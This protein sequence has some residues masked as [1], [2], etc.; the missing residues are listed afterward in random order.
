MSDDIVTP[1]RRLGPGH[2]HVAPGMAVPA[3]ARLQIRRTD[4]GSRA[5]LGRSG[6]QEAPFAHPA[7][8][9][10]DGRLLLGPAIC[11]HI[12]GNIEVEL[13]IEGADGAPLW[14]SGR[15]F[16]PEV[17]RAGRVRD[18][19]D[20]V[21][22]GLGK[23]RTEDRIIR[24]PVK[25]EN[26]G[27]GSEGG[28]GGT[29][30][31]EGQE[32][33]GGDPRGPDEPDEPPVGPGP[34]GDQ[35]EEKPGRRRL[36]LAA[37][38]LVL[39][40]LLA[41]I[42]VPLWPDAWCRQTGWFCDIEPVSVATVIEDLGGGNDT[43]APPG[44]EVAA[45]ITRGPDHLRGL[46]GDP[47][48]PADLLWRLGQALRE[49]GRSPELSDIGYEAIYDAAT[50]NQADAIAWLAS[51]NDPSLSDDPGGLGD[52]RN[53][54]VAIDLYRKAEAAGD[55]EAAGR[56]T[57]LCAWM[58]PMRFGANAKIREAYATHCPAE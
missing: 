41:G 17:P 57:S 40:L 50:R 43:P 14:L 22:G 13:R 32:G 11:G 52:D 38:G 20:P 55:A 9:T 8:R 47:A 53:P 31:R 5:F 15:L 2:A 7:T 28:A 19:D 24:A 4:V 30:G 33:P 39:A 54:G 10:E 25:T 51:A 29:D 45:L 58:R 16:W 21:L 42:S 23:D 34:G 48:V 26:T 44:D 46:V 49:T 37:G 35:E 1:A 56:I 18:L 36:L 27:E 3:D 6:W 12:P